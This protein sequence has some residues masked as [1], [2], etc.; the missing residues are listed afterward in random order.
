MVP[1]VMW[2]CSCAEGQPCRVQTCIVT[3]SL[4]A[5]RGSQAMLEAA[6][7]SA[8]CHP[9]IVQTYDYQVVDMFKSATVLR[10]EANRVGHAQCFLPVQF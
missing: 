3:S 9:N 2:L 1:I 5:T 6:V 10:T 8:V 7:S 4:A